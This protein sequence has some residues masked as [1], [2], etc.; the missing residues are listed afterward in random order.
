MILFKFLPQIL[1]ILFSV[2]GLKNSYKKI[3]NENT[4]KSRKDFNYT[5]IGMI[6]LNINF[7]FGGFYDV[8]F[9]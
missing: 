3:E 1:W 2:Y 5:I 6:F 9:E 7:Y 8:F 4:Y